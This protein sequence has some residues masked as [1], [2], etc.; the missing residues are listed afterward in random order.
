MESGCLLE[1]EI[2]DTGFDPRGHGL[3]MLLGRGLRTGGEPYY[4]VEAITADTPELEAWVRGALQAPNGVAICVGPAPDVDL[5]GEVCYIMP[6]EMVRVVSQEEALRGWGGAK[7]LEFLRGRDARRRA[8]AAAPPAETVARPRVDAVP[9]RD[10]AEPEMRRVRELE[11]ELLGGGSSR[12]RDGRPRE[13]PSLAVLPAFPP[14]PPRVAAEPRDD[15]AVG[16]GTATPLAWGGVCGPGLLQGRRR[17]RPEGLRGQGAHS[18]GAALCPPWHSG[19]TPCSAADPSRAPRSVRPGGAFRLRG[20]WAGR[21]PQ[22]P[23]EEGEAEEE[24]EEVE[25]QAKQLR[26]LAGRLFY[27]LTDRL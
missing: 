16:G 7:L 27:E 24:E 5:S 12:R 20:R 8:P 22:A 10:A 14:V 1:F 21:R 25:A 17:G 26:V 19:D 13:M 9:L 2:C 15:A 11:A 4:L 3:G 18:P 6:V 23:S